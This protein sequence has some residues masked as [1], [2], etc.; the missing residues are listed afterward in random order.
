VECTGR[1]FYMAQWSYGQAWRVMLTDRQQLD[2]V[3]MLPPA[4]TA[5]AFSQ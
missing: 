1:A 2:E 4:R 5:A 3:A